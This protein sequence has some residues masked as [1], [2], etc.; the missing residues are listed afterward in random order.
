LA[1]LYARRRASTG[2]LTAAQ[3]DTAKW[4]FV[5][6]LVGIILSLVSD[7]LEYWEG[8]PG[9]EFTTT[10]VQ[11]YSME[12][13]G[14]LLVLCAWVVLGYLLLTGEVASDQRPMSVS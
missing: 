7:I 8:S 11:G 13:L 3:P 9:Q 6:L 4:V 1:G 2:S 5:V 12:M 10:Q 14:L